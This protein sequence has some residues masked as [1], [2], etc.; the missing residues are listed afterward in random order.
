MRNGR[1]LRLARLYRP[2]MTDS[3]QE[4]PILMGFLKQVPLLESERLMLREFLISDVDDVYEIYSKKE[5]YLYTNSDIDLSSNCVDIE[6][7]QVT[8]FVE[9]W[10]IDDDLI[11]WGIELKAEKKVIGRVYLYGLVGND[12]A[13]YRVDIGYSLSPN[14]WGKNYMTEAVNLV[15]NYGFDSLRIV[16]FQ[17]EI[18]PE[19]IASIK[20]C[21]RAGF[22]NEGTLQNYSFYDNNGNCF[23]TV[24]MMALTSATQ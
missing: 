7:E 8:E 17:A 6:K 2:C 23:K 3:K 18:I 9:S 10:K 19:N 16:R 22:R 24:V 1:V 12:E 5:V 13:G 4:V 21:E 11:C 14:Y 15:V 20:V